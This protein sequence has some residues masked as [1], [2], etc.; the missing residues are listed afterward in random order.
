MN[1]RTVDFPC[2]FSHP[3]IPPLLLLR[4]GESHS[5]RLRDRHRGIGRT[6]P[7]DGPL[8]VVSPSFT[9][10]CLFARERTL[11][12]A[13]C[14]FSTGRWAMCEP[15]DKSVRPAPSD[16]CFHGTIYASHERTT[17]R[18]LPQGG[19]TRFLEAQPEQSHKQNRPSV[20]GIPRRSV[21]QGPSGRGSGC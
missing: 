12:Y 16:V 20:L 14:L 11:K 10:V 5:H 19:A 6:A 21:Y 8:T 15:N 9:S 3:D 18:H 1:L 7:L 2:R 4:S 13:A 17:P